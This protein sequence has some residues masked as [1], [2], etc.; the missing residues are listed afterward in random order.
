MKKLLSHH[1]M[2]LTATQY[3]TK[4]MTH[5]INTKQITQHISQNTCS[6]NQLTEVAAL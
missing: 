4:E 2:E 1:K 5:N 3:C 6:N